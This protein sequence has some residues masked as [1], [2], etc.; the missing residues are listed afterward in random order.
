MGAGI[1][2][3][4]CGVLLL[5]RPGLL[6][7]GGVQWDDGLSPGV[8]PVATNPVLQ[9]VEPDVHFLPEDADGGQRPLLLQL[10]EAIAQVVESQVYQPFGADDHRSRPMAVVTMNCIEIGSGIRLPFWAEL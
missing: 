3:G 7:V 4:P 6:A 9:L 10:P 8:I 2:P 5:C 1:S